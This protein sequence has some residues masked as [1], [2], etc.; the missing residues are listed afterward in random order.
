MEAPPHF[1]SKKGHHSPEF[2]VDGMDLNKNFN[3]ISQIPH[4][5]CNVFTLP[6]DYV[7]L[8]RATQGIPEEPIQ[9]EENQTSQSNPRS[10]SHDMTVNGVRILGAGQ[11]L[12]LDEAL[13]KYS[14]NPKRYKGLQMLYQN[15]SFL[16]ITLGIVSTD[17]I[18][19]GLH[20][21]THPSKLECQDD[22][23]Q[24]NACTR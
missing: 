7:A 2:A 10:S 4:E 14:S 15:I 21:L 5:Q 3:D 13:S 19:F 18:T 22:D 9:D 17:P 12:T 16:V 1:G 6:Q 20:Y 23:A 11:V 24:W 8:V